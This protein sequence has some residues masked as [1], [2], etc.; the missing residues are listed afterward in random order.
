MPTTS[1]CNRCW[2]HRPSKKVYCISC[3]RGVGPGCWPENC[4]FRELRLL[5]KTRY[6]LC[7]NFPFCGELQNQA[8]EGIIARC[9]GLTHYYDMSLRQQPPP[10]LLEI[11]Q[12]RRESQPQSSEEGWIVIGQQAESA[13]RDMIA[14]ASSSIP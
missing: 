1:K 6:G 3:G 10:P 7:S 4:L 8:W 5:S 14:A 12:A 9:L 13:W 11:T 2:L